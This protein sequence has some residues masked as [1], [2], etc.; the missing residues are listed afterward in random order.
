MTP[1]K[2]KILLK[3]MYNNHQNE[4]YISPQN[5][6]QKFKGIEFIRSMFPGHSGMESE[7]NNRRK[8]WKIP[9]YVFT[10]LVE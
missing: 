7:I 2:D 4:L 10:I 8:F 1:N 6:S 3:C 9:K 5:K